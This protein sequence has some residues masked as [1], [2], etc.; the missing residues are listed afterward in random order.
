MT[1]VTLSPELERFATEAVAQGRYRDLSDV[2]QTG[3]ALL[4]DAEA[5]VAEFVRSLEE[6]QAEGERNGFLTAEEV[7]REMSAMLDEIARTKT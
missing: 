5:E 2:V 6:A 4:K 7:H 3:L 1:T